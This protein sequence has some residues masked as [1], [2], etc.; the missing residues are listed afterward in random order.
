MDKIVNGFTVVETLEDDDNFRVFRCIKEGDSQ[1]YVLKTVNS[2][3]ISN[4]NL[5]RIHKE[6]EL[7]KLID[8]TITRKFVNFT[9]TNEIPCLVYKDFEGA[10]LQKLL[11][12]GD[13]CLKS[14]LKITSKVL[15]CLDKLHKQ[16]IIFKAIEPKNILVAPNFDD[17]RIINFDRAI[18]T[19][20]QREQISNTRTLE[21]NLYYISPEQTGRT[22]SS[23]DYRTDYY[24]LGVVLYEMLTKEVPFD[25]QDELELMHAHLA[26]TPKHPCKINNTPKAVSEIALK[27]L[28]KSAD[29]RYQSILGIKYDIDKILESLNKHESID[30]FHIA[31]HDLPDNFQ[32]PQKL[33][34]REDQLPVLEKAFEK[35]CSGERKVL[36]VSGYSGIGKTSLVRE[37]YMPLTKS[38]GIFISGKFDQYQSNVPYSAIVNAFRE[39]IK[40]LLSEPEEKLEHW[41]AAIKDALMDDANLVIDVIPEIAR[42]VPRNKYAKQLS[43]NEHQLRFKSTFQRFIKVFCSSEHPLILFLDDLQW[44][45]QATLNIIELLFSDSDVG[46]CF[47]IGA[48]RD[49]EVDSAH[50]LMTT[51]T[52]LRDKGEEVFEVSLPPL[53]KKQVNSLLSDTLHQSST[54]VRPVT[55]LIYRKTRG[56]PFF[57]E[58]LLIKLYE[59]G[60]LKFNP[61]ES[62]WQWDLLKIKQ[63]NLS[64]DVVELMVDRIKDVS[65]ECQQL[66]PIAA[67]IGS[68]FNEETIIHLSKLPAD[69]TKE[70]LR[71]AVRDGLISTQSDN[72][73]LINTND[74]NINAKF[75]LEYRFSH[76]R[77]QQAAYSLIGEEERKYIHLNIGRSMLNTRSDQEQD[78]KIFSI[79]NHLNEATNLIT[80]SDEKIEVSE[81]N[82]W[83]GKKAKDASA[84]EPAL[85]YFTNSIRLQGR[86]CWENNYEK[87]LDLYSL[88]A[89]AA[90]ANTMFDLQDYYAE[91]V[92]NKGKSILDRLKVNELK[93]QACIAQDRLPEA[94][95]IALSVLDTLGE[96]FPNKPSRW[97]F[98]RARKRTKELLGNKD[99]ASLA[100]LPDMT[101]PINLSAIRILSAVAGAALSGNPA[102]HPLT[103]SRRVDLS[104]QH[105][106]APQTSFAYASYGLILV[107]GLEDIDT[108]YDF[109]KLCMDTLHRCSDKRLN[110]RAIYVATAFVRHWKLPLKDCAKELLTCYQN[111]I[112]GGDFEFAGYSAYHFANQAFASVESL[113]NF[114]ELI[115]SLHQT[116]ANYKQERTS[117]Y[118]EV[119]HLAARVF[120]GRA[121]KNLDLLSDVYPASELAKMEEQPRY[122]QLLHVLYLNR[123]ML[124]VH[125]EKYN[126]ANQASAAVEKLKYCEKAMVVIPQGVFY[127]AIAKIG[128]FAD[129]TSTKKDELLKF[130]KQSLKQ[131]KK[132]AKF[133]PHNYEHK[134]KLVEAEYQRILGNNSKA[135]KSY[136]KSIELAISNKFT[137]DGALANLLAG[138]F[139]Q[140][141]KNHKFASAYIREARDQYS[142][143]GAIAK[144]ADIEHRYCEYFDIASNK[145][146][147]NSYD[148]ID[149]HDISEE[150]NELDYKSIL[151]AS[152]TLSGEVVLSKLIEHLLSLVIENAGAQRAILILPYGEQLKV[153]GVIDI[154]A[155]KSIELPVD[156]HNFP[157]IP[158]KLI[159]YVARTQEEINIQDLQKDNFFIKDEYFENSKLRSVLCI[160]INQ[161][162]K[163]VG[164]L[165]MEHSE[166]ANVFSDKRIEVLQLMASQAAISIETARLY[167]ALEA[168]ETKYRSIFENAAEGIFQTTEDGEVLSSNYA[169]ATI[170]GYDSVDDFSANVSHVHQYYVDMA[171]R[172]AFKKELHQNGVIRNF[173]TKYKRKDGSIVDVSLTARLVKVS[174]SIV[175]EGMIEDITQRN[176][177]EKMR[178][179]KEKAEATAEAKS[180]FLANMSHEIRTP[181]NAIIGLSELFHK[182]PL[183][184]QQRDYLDKITISSNT[185]LGIINDILDFSKIEAGKL[186]IEH[187]PFSLTDVLE[188]I[189]HLFADSISSKKLEMIIR[190]DKS[191]P[192]FLIGDPLRLNQILIN[193]ISNAIKFTEFGDITVNVSKSCEN[194]KCQLLISV[195]DTGIG[196]PTE[197]A[198][199]LFSSFTQADQ[200]TTRKY[201]GTGLGLSICKNLCN[202][203]GGSISVI[204]EVGK[205]SEFYFTVDI[206]E[207]TV[208]KI[209][210]QEIDLA[211]MAGKRVLVIDDNEALMTHISQ[212]LNEIGIQPDFA[213]SGVDAIS[214]V[215]NY[216]STY[217]ALLIDWQMPDLDGIEVYSKLTKECNVNSPAILMIPYGHGYI[218]DLATK[219]NFSDIISKPII[220]KNMID[221]IYYAI[222]GEMKPQKTSL[223]GNLLNAQ[224]EEEIRILVV[225][226][227]LINQQ[228]VKELLQQAGCKVELASNGQEA[229]E[230]N[231]NY[232]FDIIFMDLQMPVMDG[233]EATKAI[234]RGNKNNSTPIV[235]LTA[236]A[237]EGIKQKCLD[238]GMNSFLTKPIDV[239]KLYAAVNEFTNVEIE[240]VSPS[241]TKCS[242]SSIIEIDFDTAIRKMGGNKR[243]FLNIVD[244]FCKQYNDA[245]QTIEGLLANNSIP[246]AA[247]FAHSLKGL[248][249]SIGA[250]SLQEQSE[251]LNLLLKEKNKADALNE[252]PCFLQVLN[253][254][255]SLLREYHEENSQFHSDS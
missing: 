222:T 166:A 241:K 78:E 221:S 9:N 115:D 87:T 54:A 198:T 77:I 188:N 68:A 7:S 107:A 19:S 173:E 96:K 82:Y 127:S 223:G 1:L 153:E 21:S 162:G 13:L 175:Y 126:K 209:A 55:E 28:A 182:T 31:S 16:N 192:E 101:D 18:L 59:D 253:K 112:D 64:E 143:L 239:E 157:G 53:S 236:D 49:N 254:S 57:I 178:L 233:D 37:L 132:W 164:L 23:V 169:L 196:I 136:D 69:K 180:T 245:D 145:S 66:L 109:A 40:Q 183:N 133:S 217:D 238:A 12:S 140:Q 152:Q 147:E 36:M 197:T 243:L 67:C 25:Y 151:K 208:S 30:E 250:E 92:I 10:T 5:F 116:T 8:A 90:Y 161:H 214:K 165:Y 201:G 177:T 195:K 62:N 50:R 229:I 231:S 131:L 200:S 114:E 158:I 255:L 129:A 240:V 119:I 6:H 81:L 204:S 105:G 181:M 22:N 118:L 52:T 99:V 135:I 146:E 100:Q 45:D 189:T 71:Q 148:E 120:I 246:E 113:T 74:K 171:D 190:V 219:N 142:A 46:H 108:A 4:Q 111:A 34:G 103:V 144:V 159:N 89:E 47:L 155:R 44:A 84:Y 207:N 95:E 56:N 172:D 98:L 51:L 11:Q 237:L 203:M 70:V 38:K 199:N 160:P 80:D 63:Q 33:Y 14:I 17:V 211:L 234:R 97:H 206:E 15:D 29:D 227:N 72:Y 220:S 76:D 244:S 110:N 128:F 168:S 104:I 156:V 225:E 138:K 130:I 124:Y 93:I 27:L 186:T 191:V 123:L 167:E 154:E 252:M 122:H 121:K 176:R 205:G 174:D 20:T 247:R 226:D 193:L 179:A 41:R 170:L 249:G 215:A 73:K 60:L 139:F 106:H 150:Q 187:I 65:I 42:I 137:L 32:L 24:S 48:Y 134:Y 88:A 232:K 75:Y 251:K 141:Q 43:Q 248:A 228:V 212:L 91:V 230:K 83:A 102:L 94:L 213:K 58:S 210:E 79:V 35:V 2:N 194:N 85:K 117:S 185:L 86:F 163:F 61:E 235:A 242:S 184:D 218:A 125:F 149:L 216:P 202:L 3:R 26:K 224:F 39:L